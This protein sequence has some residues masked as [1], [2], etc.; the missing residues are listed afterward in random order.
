M[1][2]L[3]AT[4]S[5]LAPLRAMIAELPQAA[6]IEIARALHARLHPGP[7]AANR[8][9]KELGFLGQ[10]LNE[11]PQPPDRL[12]HIS[13]QLYDSRRE[14]SGFKGPASTG[15]TER[16][17]SWSVACRAAWGLLEDGRTIGANPWPRPRRS[18]SYRRDEAESSVLRCAAA[19]GRTPSSADYHQWIIARRSRARGRGDS[20]RGFVP[21]SSVYRLLAREVPRGNR[22]V[23]I[24]ERVFGNA[25]T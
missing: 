21:I 23:A 18:S 5:E 24:R 3:N 8:R 17:G 13:R 14:A 2:A 16:Y 22:W 11:V 19:I 15:L 20:V 7:T 4:R 12:P 10:L 9:V 1:T 6:V 25:S